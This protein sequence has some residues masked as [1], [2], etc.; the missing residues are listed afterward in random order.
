MVVHFRHLTRYVWIGV[1]ED[2]REKDDKTVDKAKPELVVEKRTALNFLLGFAVAVKH[3]LRQETGCK[4]QDLEPLISNIRSTLPTF[5]PMDEEE[6][7]FTRARKVEWYS[8]LFRR[9]KTGEARVVPTDYNLPLDI[10]LYL[11]SYF[12]AQ[13]EKKRIDPP[14]LTQLLTNLNGL[15][16]CLTQ[17]ERILTSPIPLA[18]S[19]HLS[20]SVWIYCLSLPL[21]L[22][23]PTGWT[24]II[25]VFFVSLI[26]FGLERIGTEI[27]NP[28]GYDPNDLDLD[29]FCR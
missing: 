10:T 18:Y 28:F 9:K 5:Q 8:S 14:I 24:T 20:Q 21:F 7:D 2:G 1:R 6:E 17:F 29:D 22:V 25:V 3:Y 26:L 23:G 4:Y 27:E 19:I 12:N 11:S 13:F 16:E 15:C